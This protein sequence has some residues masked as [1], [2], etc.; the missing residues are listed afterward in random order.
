MHI[1]FYR[2]LPICLP[3]SPPSEVVSG[4]VIS[5]LPADHLVRRETEVAVRFWKRAY[6][7][8]QRGPSCQR[9]VPEVLITMP[10]LRPEARCDFGSGLYVAH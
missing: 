10:A 6:W 4:A 1:L 8:G 3:Q 7:K 2:G 9:L 5:S